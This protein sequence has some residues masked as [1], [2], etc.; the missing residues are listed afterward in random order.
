MPGYWTYCFHPNTMTNE[1]LLDFENFIIRNHS[2]FI[3]F[4]DIEIDFSRKLNLFDRIYSFL[5]FKYRFIK[6]LVK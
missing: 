4:K 2:K 5:Y 6:T 3:S 1:D